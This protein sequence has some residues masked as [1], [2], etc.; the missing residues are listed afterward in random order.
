MNTLSISSCRPILAFVFLLGLFFHYPGFLHASEEILIADFEGEDYGDWK[1]EGT[2][3][4]PAPAR[5]TLPHQMSV[6][7]FLGKG[8]VNS[9]YEGDDS[10]GKLTSPVFRIEKDFIGFLIG[11]GGHE[12]LGIYL[13]VEGKRVRSAAGPN[14]VPGGSESLRWTSWDVSEFRGRDARIEIVD[15][16]TGSWGHIN[17]DHII[18][19]DI[20]K[21]PI[22]MKKTF[23]VEKDFLHF[24]IKMGNPLVQVRVEIEGKWEF[25][26]KM[27]LCG[28]EKPDFYSNL[29][30]APWKGKT[31]A[32]FAEEVSPDFQGLER[33]VQSAEMAQEDTVYTEPFRPQFHFSTRTGWINDPNG[34][35]YY[36]GTWYLFFQH[37]PFSTEWGNMS[38]GY[39]SS[40]DLFHWTEHPEAIVPDKN[41][42][43]FSGSG[44]VDW[45]N[46]IGLPVKEHPPLV[47]IYTAWGRDV[48]P[49]TA[50]T[51]GIA[52]SLD[53][54]K[55]F[56]KFSGNPVLEEISRENRDPKVIRYEPTQ[57][58]I[59]SLYMSGEDYLLLSSKD[60]KNWE[61]LCEIKNLGCSECPDF[62][63]LHVDGDSDK[64]KWVF[65]GGNGKYLIGTFDGK[66]FHRESEVLINKHGGFDYAAM[67][68]S[69]AP[70][71][72]RVQL[73]WMND[74]GKGAKIFAG[75]PFMHQLSLPRELSLRTTPSGIRLFT[76]PVRE[77]ESLR[78]DPWEIGEKPLR[79][80]QKFFLPVDKECFD[81][82]IV[83]SIDSARKIIFDLAG[84]EVQY[85]VP[86]K[87]IQLEDVKAPLDLNG[88]PLKLRLVVDRTSLELFA[89]DGEVQVAHCFRLEGERP[90]QIE[91]R[92]EGGNAKIQSAKTWKIKSVWKTGTG[93][94]R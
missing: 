37:N 15:D 87:T 30:S 85:D 33:I 18:Q 41:G 5:G 58:W 40:P 71:G 64:E 9:Y 26:A 72:R 11:G 55:T 91:I 39:A 44:V 20:S 66:D 65:W 80:G 7:G 36:K 1:I 4:G 31:V 77:L 84:Q 17:V 16:A 10:K 35:L 6:S 21:V 3:F 56:T 54:G 12:G 86:A 63:P 53:E 94:S 61:K 22:E 50:V 14:V 34:L 68:F 82:E 69:D 23:P 93:K 13:W 90:D 38:W 59:M 51:Q 43:I 42:V 88:N 29:H 89:Q 32:I 73:S 57:S 74:W 78:T 2:A 25:E 60:L 8:L 52:Y 62:F 28:R 48:R 47:L 19:T 76:N 83:L 27:P 24:P 81:S 79:E 92:C 67:S 75:M 70:E 45:N 49:P 46:T